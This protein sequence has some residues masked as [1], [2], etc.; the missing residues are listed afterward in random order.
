VCVKFSKKILGMWAQ[1]KLRALLERHGYAVVG[2]ATSGEETIALAASCRPRVV[3]M[4][5]E[6]PGLGGL[7][8]IDFDTVSRPTSIP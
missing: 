4:D 8:A 6:M 1:V 7:A 2:T 5:V 3:V